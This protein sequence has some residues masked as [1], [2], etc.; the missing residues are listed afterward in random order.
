MTD[1]GRNFCAVKFT[2][3]EKSDC[4]PPEDKTNIVVAPYFI[5]QPPAEHLIRRLIAFADTA[6]E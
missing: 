2:Y 1:S 6:L 4:A 5:K 3:V